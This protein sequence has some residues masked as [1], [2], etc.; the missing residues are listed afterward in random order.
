MAPD[1]KVHGVQT[2]VPTSM[3][4]NSGRTTLAWHLTAHQHCITAHQHYYRPSVIYLIVNKLLSLSLS[5]SLPWYL[6]AQQHYIA[7]Q[8]PYHGT[9]SK[10]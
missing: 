4:A 7:A 8:Q 5:L 6:T 9:H 10:V 2:M 1:S 3:V